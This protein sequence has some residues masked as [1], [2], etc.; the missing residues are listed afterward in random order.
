[1]GIERPQ[2]NKALLPLQSFIP[3]ADSS[4]A[5]FGRTDL[6][7]TGSYHLD[8]YLGGGYG[9]EGNYEIILIFGN[10]GVGKS[11]VALNMVLDPIAKG[12]KVGLMILEDDPADVLNRMRAMTDGNIDNAQNVFFAA[13]QSNG[14]TLEQAM[15]AIDKWFEKCDV[16]LLDHLEYLF[17]GSVMESESQVWNKQAI[18]M[19]HLNSLMKKNGKTII[20][21]QHVNKSQAEG[22]DKIKG[23]G[24]F[25]QTCTKVIEVKRILNGWTLMLHKTRFTPYR[26]E[27][28]E[29]GVERFRVKDV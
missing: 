26:T 12:K 14:Y 6:Y 24:A 25:V 8:E 16:I 20:L 3:K 21:V 5:N 15:E 10:S 11:L 28:Q 2:F 17:A 4:K 9:R 27:W 22:V 7:K 18:W 29:V 23:S 19:R 13:D 1:M